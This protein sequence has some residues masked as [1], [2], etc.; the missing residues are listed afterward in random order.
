[1][2]QL[3]PPTHL[4]TAFDLI[5]RSLRVDMLSESGSDLR[6]GGRCER[7]GRWEHGGES[8]AVGVPASFHSPYSWFADFP[9]A[10]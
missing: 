10:I 5:L 4:F 6:H 2:A 7:G 9:T 8:R 1:M 3:V